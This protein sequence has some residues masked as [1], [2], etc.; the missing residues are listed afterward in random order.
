MKVY[1]ETPRFLLRELTDAD[2]PGLFAL[3][4][5]PEVHRYLGNKP[6]K[7][8]E[9]SEAV[10]RLVRKQYEENGIGRWAVI[11]KASGDFVGWSGLKYE[12][13]LRSGL[14]YYDLGY[15]LRRPYWGQGIASETAEAAMRYGFHEMGLSELFAA[16]HPDNI[17]SNKVLQKLGFIWM[18]YFDY[19]GTLHNWYRLGRESVVR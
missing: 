8:I 11:D 12:K 16:A 14:H 19:E 1:V 7:T 6:V 5:D 10:V 18:E 3:D 13:N 9:E 2:V 15:R 17:G 4:S